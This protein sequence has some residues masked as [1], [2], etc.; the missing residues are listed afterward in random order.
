MYISRRLQDIISSQDE[1]R[2]G[3]TSNG[4]QYTPRTDNRSINC[5]TRETKTTTNQRTTT[6]EDQ[7][8]EDLLILE[9]DPDFCRREINDNMW[10]DPQILAMLTTEF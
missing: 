10:A 9:E 1:G 7:T 3:T 4:D 8:T 5:D 2:D 6:F